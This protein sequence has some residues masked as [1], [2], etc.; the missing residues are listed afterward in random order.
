M[1]RKAFA[2]MMEGMA[3]A[4]A[5]V[6]GDGDRA[7]VARPL[8]VKMVRAATRKTQAEFARTYHLP[9]GTVRDWEQRR[10]Q[11]DAPARILLSLIEADPL[12][13]EQLI[14]NMPII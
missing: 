9:I 13:V 10:R 8:D 1:A 7:R 12:G 4:I 3:D 14:A 6:E 11:P 5:H 2:M